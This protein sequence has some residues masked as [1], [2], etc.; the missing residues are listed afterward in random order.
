MKGT[1][2][3]Y[4]S[5]HYTNPQRQNQKH[6]IKLVQR[7]GSV[8]QRL[9]AVNCFFYATGSGETNTGPNEAFPDR[10]NGLRLTSDRREYV[11]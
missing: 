4:E 2:T 9:D 7:N 1:I 3:Y 8:K 6:L 11:K 5:Y 10:T